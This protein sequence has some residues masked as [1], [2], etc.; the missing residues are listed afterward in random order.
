MVTKQQLSEALKLHFGFDTFKGNQE[1][2]MLSLLEGRDTFVLMPTGGGK[3]I[4]FQ[5]PA[6]AQEG[7]CIVITPLIA[8]MKDQV[9][10]LRKRGIK[11]LAVY[12]GM[13]RQEILT[14]LENCIFGDY[15]FPDNALNSEFEKVL[16][17]VLEKYESES[18]ADYDQWYANKVSFAAEAYLAELKG[19][20]EV[21]PEPKKKAEPKKVVE[22]QEQ[23]K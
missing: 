10:N 11:A 15:K 20:E 18:E 3:S 9:Q 23:V 19:P 1:D 22:T 17:S 16:E 8:L 14:A 21:K 4:T 12:S 5:V 2:I 7:I 6:L 13:T